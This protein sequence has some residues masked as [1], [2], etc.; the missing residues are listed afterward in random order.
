VTN[1]DTQ[2]ASKIL[3]LPPANTILGTQLYIRDLTG[4]ASASSI[5]VSTQQFD[6]MENYASTITLN[7]N[8]QTFRVIPY[9]TTRYAIT[10]NYTQGLTPFQYAIRVA[11]GFT[12][13]VYSD[14]DWSTFAVSPDGSYMLAGT[15][16]GVDGV[17]RSPTDV[18]QFT[19][20]LDTPGSYY[21]C[22]IGSSY[23]YI[24]TSSQDGFYRSSDQGQHWTLLPW[25]N[26][27]MN[28]INISCNQTGDYFLFITTSQV[29]YSFAAG[30]EG[31]FVLI[32]PE[33][34][35]DVDFTNCAIGDAPSESQDDI[36]AFVTAN[37][38]GEGGDYIYVATNIT[39][40]ANFVQQGP[41]KYWTTVS[42]NLSGSIAY[43]LDATDQQLY[44]STDTGQTWNVLTTPEPFYNSQ[45]QCSSDGQIF[46]G[47]DGS[48][49]RFLT[50]DGGASFEAVGDMVSLLPRYGLSS[51]GGVSL[52][53]NP[54]SSL[55]V[56]KFTVS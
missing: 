45:I 32:T 34:T 33:I 36:V 55:Y 27:G 29:W 20:V 37:N 31:S 49:Q 56:G 9:S 12:E 1:V 53:G 6:L 42:C 48:S 22:A 51:N 52:F 50:K 2:L 18:I 44:K 41:K 40:G 25:P 10:L 5:F 26:E 24:L 15:S 21:S 8:F 11:I 7:Q 19:E 47:I 17:Y 43:A 28:V 13:V 38:S 16:G 14:K 3:M 30:S 35:G 39:E 46:F 23:A 4:N 54:F